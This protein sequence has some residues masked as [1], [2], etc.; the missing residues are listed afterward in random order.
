MNGDEFL[1]YMLCV[2]AIEEDMIMLEDKSFFKKVFG[3]LL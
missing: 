1:H 3:L 2:W